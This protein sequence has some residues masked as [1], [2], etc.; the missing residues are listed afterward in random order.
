VDVVVIHSRVKVVWRYLS[1]IVVA[2]VILNIVIVIIVISIITFTAGLVSIISLSVSVVRLFF[3][4]FLLLNS[5]S[6]V[7]LRDLLF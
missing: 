4:L 5:Y 6:L 2:A 1:A 7:D 3:H